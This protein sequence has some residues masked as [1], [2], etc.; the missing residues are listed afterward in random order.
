MTVLKT[1]KGGGEGY[2]GRLAT[3]PELNLRRPHCNTVYVVAGFSTKPHRGPVMDI[4]NVTSFIALTI[5]YKQCYK[6]NYRLLQETF[7]SLKK[8]KRKKT[9]T[10]VLKGSVIVR[11]TSPTNCH[12]VHL[13]C[14]YFDF[15]F[16]VKQQV[17]VFLFYN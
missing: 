3:G 2:V 9:K 8:K 16:M 17:R 5:Q 7:K 10:E 6:N 14:C 11:H 1:G 12:S 4:F 13:L 15:D